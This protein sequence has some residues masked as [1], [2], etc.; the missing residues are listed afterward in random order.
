MAPLSDHLY[1]IGTVERDFDEPPTTPKN[2]AV[3]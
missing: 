2:I 1:R 3:R